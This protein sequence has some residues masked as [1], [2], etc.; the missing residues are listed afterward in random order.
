[1]TERFPEFPARPVPP[2]TEDTRH[3]WDQTRERR[4][5][6]QSCRACHAVQFY[7]RCLCVACGSFEVELVPA[8]GRGTVYSRTVLSTSPNPDFFVTPYVVALVRLEEG[9][10]VLTNIVGTG[11][12]DVQCDDPVAVTWDAMPDGRH[13]P[14]FTLVT[15]PDPA[16]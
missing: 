2:V 16:G 4:L 12:S 15:S 6:V 10:V 13:L 3:W 8:S 9:P 1:M 11:A 7:P 14:L 5:T